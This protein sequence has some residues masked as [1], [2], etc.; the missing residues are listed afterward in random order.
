MNL[1]FEFT[2]GVWGSFEPFDG[3]YF[4]DDLSNIFKNYGGDKLY[5]IQ[6][7]KISSTEYL[8]YYIP[9]KRMLLIDSD[10]K[11]RKIYVTKN[12]IKQYLNNNKNFGSWEINTDLDEIVIDNFLWYYLGLGETCGILNEI[13]VNK[14]QKAIEVNKLI[15][16]YE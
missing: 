13:P 7:K 15:K 4:D 10:Q 11:V 12:L 5:F 8:I 1:V 3:E 2:V 9:T 16:K 14:S 6:T